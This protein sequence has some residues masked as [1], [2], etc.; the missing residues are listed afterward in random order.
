MTFLPQ[1]LQLNSEGKCRYF[2]CTLFKM[3][4]LISFHSG[5]AGWWGSWGSELLSSVRDK[6]G[7]LQSSF[8][9]VFYKSSSSAGL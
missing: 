8:D 9:D 2:Y 3:L 5:G 1:V 4:D 7:M 6:V